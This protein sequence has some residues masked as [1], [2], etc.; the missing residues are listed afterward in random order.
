MAQA[1]M[2]LPDDEQ[3]LTSRRLFMPPPQ[4]SRRVAFYLELLYLLGLRNAVK[5]LVLAHFKPRAG[6]TVLHTG[7]GDG[8]LS[9]ELKRLHPNVEL[10]VVDPDEGALQSAAQQARAA[11]RDMVFQK[12]YL[13][14]LPSASERC[15]WVLCTLLL[16]RLRG[17]DRGEAFMEF[18][19]VLKPG[20]R[21]LVVD[22]GA[23]ARGLGG[24]ALRGLAR[25]QGG[26]AEQQ[27]IGLVEML[28][29]SSLTQIKRVGEGPLGLQ[30]VLAQKG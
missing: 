14:D 2:P 12:G 11:S 25:H 19:R 16:Y 30:A 18:T 23:L 5:Q 3:A 15:D 21:L 24:W 20:G 28:Q 29:L 13:Q 22:F 1:R 6:E 9:V 10:E 17:E 27:S 8:T 4:H 7:C 26:I